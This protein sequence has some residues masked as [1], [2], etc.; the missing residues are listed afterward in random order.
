LVAR[1]LAVRQARVR[2]LAR[3]PM[4]VPPTEP[5]LDSY[6]DMEMDLSECL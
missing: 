6:E 5:T 3:H 4:E 2:I 1:W